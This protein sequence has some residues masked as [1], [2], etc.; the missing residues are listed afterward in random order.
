MRILSVAELYLA[1]GHS[2]LFYCGRC[3]TTL[4]SSESWKSGRSEMTFLAQLQQ[5]VMAEEGAFP[6]GVLSGSPL[7]HSRSLLYQIGRRIPVVRKLPLL[8]CAE[9][10]DSIC[11]DSNCLFKSE[12]L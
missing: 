10:Y 2:R 9:P 1:L 11:S 6:I 4:H 7:A 3:K 12:L 5:S 8:S